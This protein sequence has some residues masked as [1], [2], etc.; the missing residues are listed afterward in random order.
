MIEISN[1]LIEERKIIW[2]LKK[3][4]SKLEDVIDM[5]IDITHKLEFL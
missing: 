2:L 1:K 3:I 5:F 4:E